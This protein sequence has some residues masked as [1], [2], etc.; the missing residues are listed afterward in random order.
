[1]FSEPSIKL[2]E[3]DPIL[4]KANIYPYFLEDAENT[5]CLIILPGGGYE[6]VS[7][8]E[9]PPIAGWLNSIGISAIVL[10][11]TV[12]EAIYPE[13]QQQ[14]LYCVR[15]AKKMAKEWNIDSNKIGVIGFSAGGHLA[16]CASYGFNREEWLIDP[17]NNLDGISARPELN[18]LA[19]PVISGVKY[20]H[21][22][23]FNN[24]L[25]KNSSEEKLKA[26]SWE[27]HITED[28]PTTFLWHT[29]SDSV[30]RVENSYLLALA[31]SAKDIKHECH[32]YEKGKHGLGLCSIGERYEP[33][34]KD[35]ILRA[36]AWLKLQEF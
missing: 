32:I 9:G 7:H 21:Q 4:S 33:H 17:D 5:P 25:G 22:A 28:A 11:Y 6:M 16:S 8:Q 13:P 10:E 3:S 20:P 29:V 31:L 1:M 19:Y 2:H 23:S 34:T 24:L 14:A 27:Q 18:I 26:V 12:G 36:E 15:L 30:V 35:W